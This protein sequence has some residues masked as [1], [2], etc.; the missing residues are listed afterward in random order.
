METVFKSVI[1]SVA[2]VNAPELKLPW[3]W[4]HCPSVAGK[5]NVEPT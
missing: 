2:N 4:A 3:Y 5:F 1:P